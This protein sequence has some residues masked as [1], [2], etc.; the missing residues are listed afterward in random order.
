MMPF[1][2]HLLAL[3]ALLLLPLPLCAD[4][5]D[6]AV[7]SRIEQDVRDLGSADFAVRDAATKRL[8]KI[9][10]PAIEPLAELALGEDLEATDR[11]LQILASFYDI[12]DEATLEKLD[13]ALEQL[14]D[15]PAPSAARRAAAAMAV[16]AKNRD[17]RAV[18]RLV[19]LGAMVKPLGIGRINEDSGGQ[20][21]VWLDDQWKG[22]DTELRL[23]RRLAPGRLRVLYRVDGCS[24]SLD[25]ARKLEQQIPNLS[26]QERGPAC[27]GLGA[28]E[29]KERGFQ[30]QIASPEGSIAA[31]GMQNN[32]II[33]KYDG[34]EVNNFEQ[35]VEMIKKNKV[36]DTVKIEFLRTQDTDA[37]RA[38]VQLSVDVRLKSWREVFDEAERAEREQ[39]KKLEISP[40]PDPGPLP[41]DDEDDENDEEETPPEK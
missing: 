41:D 18:K 33:V 17:R 8:K 25:A 37:G 30:I 7:Q 20:L 26:F 12:D 14:V 2:D 3:I 31:A 23:F 28:G 24:A 36:G 29:P 21:D 13:T 39:E 6:A 9:G 1:R 5:P 15:S 27:L 11:A 10:R 40:E 32:D 22:G 19:E 4:E 34:Q 16:H 35:L 38:L